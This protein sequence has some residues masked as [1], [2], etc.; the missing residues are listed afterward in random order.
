MHFTAR[1]NKGVWS[2]DSFVIFESV[3][4]ILWFNRYRS[5]N[6]QLT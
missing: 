5:K 4:Q 3:D 2:K 6:I 1:L